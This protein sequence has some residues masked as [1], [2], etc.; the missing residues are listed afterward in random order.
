MIGHLRTFCAALL[1]LA[2]ATG[3][4]ALAQAVATATGPG[5][6]VTVGG[7]VALGHLPYGDRNLAGA[8]IFS[9]FAPHWRFSFEAEARYLR[10]HQAEDVTETNYLVGPRVLVFSGRERVYAKF[11]VGDGH[12]ELPFHYARGDF[13]TFAPGAGIDVDLNNYVSL[14]VIDLEYQ[15]WNNFPYG[16]MQPYTA[17][18]GVSFRITR[19]VQFPKGDRV[20]H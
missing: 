1:C 16:A 19:M 11:L 8:W 20:R 10:L 12:V 5:A 15:M 2:A 7:G 18:A 9:D 6:S 14:R 4:R 17:S 13:L 3:S